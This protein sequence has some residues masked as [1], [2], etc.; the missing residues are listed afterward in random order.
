MPNSGV[1]I[2]ASRLTSAGL[3]QVNVVLKTTFASDCEL[4]GCAAPVEP[5]A[6]LRPSLKASSGRWQLAQAWRPLADSRVSKNRKRPSST[7]ACD[8]R[9][10]S[11]TRGTGSDPGTASW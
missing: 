8:S 6:V 2:C 1:S 3:A 5:M 7:F 4:R 11:G 9:L 10:S